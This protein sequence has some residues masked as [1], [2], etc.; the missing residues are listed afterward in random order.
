MEL[1]VAYT[2]PIANQAGFIYSNSRGCTI[3]SKN[4]RQMVQGFDFFGEAIYE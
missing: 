1:A 3:I 2:M 4:L